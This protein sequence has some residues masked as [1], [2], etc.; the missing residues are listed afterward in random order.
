ME[1]TLAKKQKTKKNMEANERTKKQPSFISLLS[2][3]LLCTSFS[4]MRETL[5]QN[6]TAVHVGFFFNGVGA[7]NP[8]PPPA[9]AAAAT[10]SQVVTYVDTG[11]K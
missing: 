4:E 7:L 2:A 8:P 11:G 1:I 3:L 9:A 5:R 6:T 10:T